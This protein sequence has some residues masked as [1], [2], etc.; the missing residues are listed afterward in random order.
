MGSAA[1][2]DIP[3]AIT[4]VI[5]RDTFLVRERI[6]LHYQRFADIDL[7]EL[8]HLGHLVQHLDQVGV[9]VRSVF[10]QPAQI[11]DG[12]RD[13]LQEV[14]FLL[15]VP[16]ETIRTKYL[17]RAEENKVP[18][19]GIELLLVNRHVFGEFV[20]VLLDKFMTEFVVEVRLCLP[21][22]RG[23]VVIDRSASA[24]LEVNKVWQQ[25]TLA[26]DY[27]D[28]PALEVA[29]HKGVLLFL[30][31]QDIS[32]AFE[33]VLEFV[34]LEVKSCCL[35]EAIF[36]VVEIPTDTSEVEFRLRV[37]N[38]E[39]EVFRGFDLELCQGTHCLAEHCFLALAEHAG[40]SS[41]GYIVEQQ[42]VAQILLHVRHLIVAHGKH[43]GDAESLLGEMGCHSQEGVVFVVRRTLHTDE[44]DG[45]V[46]IVDAV[47]AAVAA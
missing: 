3:A 42:R 29:V 26:L 1:V 12:K 13:R 34:F 44:R 21:Q 43:A 18:Q 27:H 46:L 7:L 20:E 22:E 14:R 41:F 47:I 45:F 10:E 8:L 19:R 6:D 31:K 2:K 39:V 35:E 33:L 15:K 38:I 4:A 40:F 17:H 30:L 24:A 28:V 32:E 36:E 25:F 16:A 23:N 37:A 11:L 9:V 5:G